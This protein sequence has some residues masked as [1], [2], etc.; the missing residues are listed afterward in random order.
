MKIEAALRKLKNAVIFGIAADI[1]FCQKVKKMIMLL[2]VTINPI[3][4]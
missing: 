2:L 3:V 1:L 4:N